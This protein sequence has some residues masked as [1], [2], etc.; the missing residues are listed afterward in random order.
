VADEASTATW[1]RWGPIG[2]FVAVE[3]YAVVLWLHAGRHEWFYLDEWDFLARRRASHLGDLFR[4][5]NEH[6]VTIPVLVYRAL[7]STFGLRAY[8]PYRLVVLVLY[9]AAAALLFVVIRR[10]GVQPWIAAAAASAYAL[11][12]PGWEN[13]IKPF[14]MTF[15]GALALGLLYLILADHDGGFDR[16]DWFGLG[17]GLLALMMSG[18]ALTMIAVVGIA[19]LLRRG[20][21]LAL[22]HV[23]PLAAV[24]AIWVLAFGPAG[25]VR[26]FGPKTSSTIG[27]DAHFVV[28]GYGRAFSNLGHYAALGWVLLAL[29]VAGGVLAWRQRFGSAEFAQLAAPIALLVGSLGYLASTAVGRA[30]FGA[31]YAGISRHVSLVTAMVLP[32]VAV[33]A[34][35]I[36]RVWR[37]FV[38]VV[39]AVLLVGV[40]GG[41]RRV[42]HTQARLDSLYIRTKLTILSVAHDPLARRV[43]PTLRPEQLSA[44]DVTVGWLLQGVREHRI[45]AAPK[46]IIVDLRASSDFRLTFFQNGDPAPKRICTKLTRPA[47]LRL[48][49]DEVIGVYDNPVTIIP[50]AQ[51]ALVGFA[52]L[53]APREGNAIKVLRPVRPVVINSYGPDPGRVCVAPGKPVPH[54]YA[55]GK[56]P[57]EIGRSAPPPENG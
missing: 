27:G 37:Y 57:N 41:V 29:L 30:S 45:P 5:H 21:R 1:N 52:P 8:L 16:R 20:W 51:P 53:F 24:F 12:G 39:L 32:A 28:T 13:A 19:V 11:F 49:Q 35:A 54:P 47:F 36:A 9:L 40:V 26:Q 15:T 31:G 18:V 3:V 50:L 14:Q 10:A 23:A 33:A 42:D 17:V 4:A 46:L 48:Q 7:Y 44:R 6:W 56:A 55:P 38:P 2:L 25:K 22:A 34:D 43:P